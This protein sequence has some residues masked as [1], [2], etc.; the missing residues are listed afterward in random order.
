MFQ[1]WYISS[2]P[3]LQGQIFYPGAPLPTMFSL[4]CLLLFFSTFFFTKGFIGSETLRFCWTVALTTKWSFK[5]SEI[6]DVTSYALT[7]S[8]DST[9]H[10]Q[11]LSNRSDFINNGKITPWITVLLK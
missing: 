8:S 2:I 11:D 9:R 3:A 6:P 1:D 10:I 5:P 7:N 4:A